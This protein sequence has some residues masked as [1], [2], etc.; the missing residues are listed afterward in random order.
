MTLPAPRGVLLD[1]GNTL[2]VE[3]GFNR[4]A[5]NA[6][7]LE[8]AASNPRAVALNDLRALAEE[9]SQE[10]DARRY[11]A[12]IEFRASE[13]TRLLYHRVGIRFEQS[14]AELEL[15][16]WRASVKM[17]P[18]P[19]VRRALAVLR[20]RNLP[21]A[22]LS[23]SAFSGHVLEDEL[24]RHGLDDGFAFVMASADY[25]FRKP[26]PALFA[27]AAGRLDLDPASLWFIG[28]SP[29]YD[30]AGARAAGM[31]PVWYNPAGRTS[32]NDDHLAEL[33][34]WSALEA[35]LVEAR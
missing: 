11:G 14:D 1:L 15:A 24:A 34:D 20:G 31:T 30:M 25:G 22:V 18:A 16:F 10:I 33:R 29:S 19:D 8:L 21:H 4:G 32:E 28:D 27:T 35:L 26:H 13:V 12:Q 7:L 2:L 17:E 23:N 5:G 9:L 3:V 6:R